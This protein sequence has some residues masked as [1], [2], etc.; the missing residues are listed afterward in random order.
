MLFCGIFLLECG[1]YDDFMTSS[2]P[3]IIYAINEKSKAYKR[4]LQSWEITNTVLVPF[5]TEKLPPLQFWQSCHI[6][7]QIGIF[8]TIKL[9]IVEIGNVCQI[10][11]K[12]ISHNWR[13]C[14]RVSCGRNYNFLLF[15]KKPDCLKTKIIS[16]IL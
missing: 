14:F 8:I 16:S 4:S 1:I 12:M 13:Y 2:L 11:F 6:F 3:F 15:L 5:Y 7:Y 10:C 9:I